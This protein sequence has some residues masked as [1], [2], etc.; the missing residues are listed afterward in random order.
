MMYVGQ[1]SVLSGATLLAQAKNYPGTGK[2]FNEVGAG[3]FQ[4]GS[5]LGAH[6]G[7]VTFGGANALFSPVVAGNYASSPNA[8]AL[9]ITGDLSMWGKVRSSDYTSGATQYIGGKYTTTGEQRSYN[10]HIN[11]T[12][13][14][15]IALSSAGTG[16]TATSATST[17]AL[18]V[19]DATD[20]YVG[21]TRRDSDNRIQFWYSTDGTT[22]TQLGTDVTHTTTDIFSSSAVMT[23]GA[24]S[25][26]GHF[27]GSIYRFS[28]WNGIR[29]FNAGTGGTLVFDANFE[30]QATGTT[31]FTESSSNAATVTVVSTGSDTN[32]PQWLPHS[33]SQNPFGAGIDHI[34][35]PALTTVSQQVSVAD[36]AAF[37]TTGDIDLRVWC[38][39]TS[40]A[41]GLSQSLINRDNIGTDPNRCWALTLGTT[42]G[43]GFSWYPAGTTA[44]QL[45]ANSTALVTTV[46]SNGQAGWVRVTLDVDNG[47]G[48]YDV[49]FYTSTDGSNWTQLGTTITG[50]STT[51][52]IA[53]NEP[54][55]VGDRRSSGAFIFSFEGKIARAQFY[56]GIDGTL[57]A[58][59]NPEGGIINSTASSLTGTGDGLTWTINRASTGR[60]TTWVDRDR[61]LLGT[62]DRFAVIGI[63]PSWIGTE[64]PYTALIAFRQ[65][66]TTIGGGKILLGNG[67]AGV[68]LNSG[69]SIATTF[70][71]QYR[72]HISDGVSAIASNNIAVS[73]FNGTQSGFGGTY[74]PTAESIRLQ[75]TS[76]AG[77][78]VTASLSSGLTDLGAV[79]GGT[80]YLGY[81]STDVVYTDMEVVGVAVFNRVLTDAE[82][83]QAYQELYT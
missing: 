1:N 43:L 56:H 12:G 41:S 13:F 72:M 31:S 79:G 80:N 50:G 52:L 49:R 10:F 78:S 58:D 77:S 28:I 54:L 69:A 29:D 2:W 57:I 34:Y 32:D 73:S 42:G 14:L 27:N 82:S 30:A 65:F 21:V 75:Y 66:G 37:D 48:G 83:Q 19:S 81:Q 45:G 67:R 38:C 26:V 40:W 7:P 16:A 4:P 9:D 5:V 20:V 59:F 8:A 74:D 24:V 68:A 60:K 35:H 36:N 44:S 6:I 33:T 55:W 18:P 71:N 22:Y 64:A 51:N 23:V 15:G 53:S 11:S 39:P 63:T 17:A 70:S 3:Y 47:A 25:D 62:D 46:F 76:N 61:W